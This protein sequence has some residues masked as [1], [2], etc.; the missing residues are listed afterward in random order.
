VLTDEGSRDVAVP[1]DRD[2]TFEPQM[3][4]KRYARRFTGIDD[5]ILALFARG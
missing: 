4:L 2:G 5:Q 3:I 1:R